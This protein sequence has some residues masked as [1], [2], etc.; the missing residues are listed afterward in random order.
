M[1][2][3]LTSAGIGS[4]LKPYTNFI[5]KGL[6]PYKNMPAIISI[7]NSYP[8]K[9]RFIICVGH[10][11]DHI[12]EII[13]YLKLNKRVKLV[14]IKKFN[15]FN[16]SLS[17]TLKKAV[18]H[19]NEP[20]IFHSNDSMVEKINLEINNKNII[21]VKKSKKQNN[22]YRKISI[23]KDRYIKKF[24]SK[25]YYDKNLYDYIGITYIHDFLKFKKFINKYSKKDGESGFI[26]KYSQNFKVNIIKNWTDIGNIKDFEKYAYD[27]HHVLPKK[28]QHIYFVKDKVIKF[29]SDER[30]IDNLIKKSIFLKS[31]TPRLNKISKNFVAYGY[32]DGKMYNQQSDINVNQLLNFFKEKLWKKQIKINKNK[33]FIKSLNIFYYD[34]SNERIQTFLDDNKKFKNTLNINKIKVQKIENLINKIDWKKLSDV[35]PTYMHGDLHFENIL[36]SNKKIIALDIRNDFSEFNFLGDVY[37][38]LSKILHGIIVNHEMIIKNLYEYINNKNIININISVPT[39]FKKNLRDFYDFCLKE[40]YNINKIEIICALI[41]LNIACLHHKPYS[42]FLFSLGAL[43]LD[44]NL[45]KNKLLLN[46]IF[47]ISLLNNEQNN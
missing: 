22:N 25:N 30:K 21:F 36:I 47:D 12:E 44:L 4:R 13:N 27:K 34:K 19:I 26:K 11:K 33:K 35:K 1:L 20:F 32:V 5:N 31:I 14:N 41:Y 7:I 46:Y 3:L 23:S 16:G 29:F 37:Y 39:K 9:T 42:Y 10:F 38:D 15:E 28:D 8:D 24:Y 17:Y 45:N 2:V 40:N 18:K 6:L 43:M